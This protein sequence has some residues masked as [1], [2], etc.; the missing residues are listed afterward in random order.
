MRFDIG[1]L[2]SGERSLPFGLLVFKSVEMPLLGQGLTFGWA[3]LF[4]KV[5]MYHFAFNVSPI[6]GTFLDCLGREG[7]F[8]FF[9]YCNVFFRIFTV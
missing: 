5:C 1:T 2:D 8:S 6:L 4:F 3:W 7:V 9:F